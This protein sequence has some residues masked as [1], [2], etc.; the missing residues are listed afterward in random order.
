M[1][2]NIVR[3]AIVAITAL[4][5]LAATASAQND[6]FQSGTMTVPFAFRVGDHHFNAGTYKLHSTDNGKVLALENR[7]S[8]G[9]TTTIAEASKDSHTTYAVFV[10]LGS[11]YILDQIQLKGNTSIVLN[12]SGRDLKA[13]RERRLAAQGSQ[14]ETAQLEVAVL[15]SG[16]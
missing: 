16:N 12:K 3:F 13:M 1:K 6:T 14:T 9:L 15:H 7:E 5:S 4:G 10:R 11:G 8:L 2:S